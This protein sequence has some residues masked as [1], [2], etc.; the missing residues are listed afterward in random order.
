MQMSTPAWVQLDSDDPMLG[1]YME[2]AL[3]TNWILGVG[4][5][6]TLSMIYNDLYVR[7]YKWWGFI[8]DDVVPE[9]PEFDVK[10]IESAGEDGMAV[11]DGG[12]GTPHFVLGKNLPLLTG[13]LSLPG[14]SRL[15]IDTVWGD[16]AGALGVLRRNTNV[17]LKHHHFSNRLALM[18]ETYR[19]PLKAKDRALY[20][21]WKMVD[22]PKIRG[23]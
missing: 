22:F 17:V 18:D 8:A 19:K 1:G 3:P 15:Y 23:G 5:R 14:L 2:L 4:P 7:E 13:W 9:T 11:P 16:I 6:R 10:L 21:A 20:E 12:N